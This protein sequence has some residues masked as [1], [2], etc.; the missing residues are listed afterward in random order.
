MDPQ[1]KRRLSKSKLL[2]A[3]VLIVLVVLVAYT[4]CDAPHQ[5][6][7]TDK[8]LSG[9]KPSW[10]LL[11]KEYEQML[12]PIAHL[13]ETHPDTYWF[14]VSWLGTA[15]GTPSW[16]GYDSEKW[17]DKTKRKGIDCSGFARVMQDRIYCKSIRGSSQ[18]IYVRNCTPIKRKHIQMGDLV[19]F[20]APHAKSER[21]VHVGIYLEDDVFV[22]A[23]SAR[24]AESGFGISINTL[25]EPH[26]KEDLIAIG[27]VKP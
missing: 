20:K 18:Q 25:L 3:A 14:I 2:A 26:W 24:S 4:T 16:Q 23:T 6:K 7:N 22:H 5:E 17:Q 15:Y 1:P 21:I 19:F 10:Q 27:R 11:E 13:S 12:S 9:I 8:K